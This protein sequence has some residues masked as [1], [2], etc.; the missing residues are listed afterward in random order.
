[1]RNGEQEIA[2]R[3]VGVTNADKVLFPDDGITK[4]QLIDYYV[5]AAELI[6]PHLQGRPVALRR[7]PDG[8]GGEGFFQKAAPDHYPDWIPRVAVD[9]SQG[10]VVHQV[11]VNEPASLAFLAQQAAIELHP[12]LW[13]SDRRG[14][15]DQLI[16][17][18]DPPGGDVDAARTAARH[19]RD[20]LEELG[21]APRLKTT[22]SKGYHVHVRLDGRSSD[23][24]LRAVA[25]DIAR[26]VLLRAPNELTIEHRIANRRGRVFVDWLRNSYGQTAVAAYSVRALP[27][28]PVAT[29]LDWSELGTVD[30]GSYSI[31]NLFRRLGQRDDPWAHDVEPVALGDLQSRLRNLHR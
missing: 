6:L 11:E 24:D 28:A 23:D 21:V 17:D 10:G 30:P 4:G 14:R 19:V 1:V 15:P 22:G 12:V 3:T 9:T 7:F 31:Q 25:L 16:L 29:P 8:I 5:R 13:R 26:T 18:L 20:V 2:G 27:G